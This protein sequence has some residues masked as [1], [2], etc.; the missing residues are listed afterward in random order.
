LWWALQFAQIK[1]SNATSGFA[2]CFFRCQPDQL[3]V[4]A[5]STR[6]AQM[7]KKG[8]FWAYFRVFAQLK[9]AFIAIDLIAL[10]ATNFGGG[11]KRLS[12]GSRYQHE[13]SPPS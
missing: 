3:P 4:I 12:E 8:A 10:I 9:R 2:V 5:Q 11:P 6:P 13:A 7:D 1:E